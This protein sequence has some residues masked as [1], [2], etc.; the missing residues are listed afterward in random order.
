MI[1][2]ISYTPFVIFFAEKCRKICQFKNNDISL[3]RKIAM[4]R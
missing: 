3:H 1:F 2:F 4:A